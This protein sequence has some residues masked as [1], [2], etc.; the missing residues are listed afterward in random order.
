[1]GFSMTFWEL[2]DLSEEH[3]PYGS[4][5]ASRVVELHAALGEY[6]ARGLPFLAPVNL[7][8]PPLLDSLAGTPDLLAAADLDRARREWASLEPVL[9]SR[10]AFEARFPGVPL[11]AV[12]GDAPS[13]N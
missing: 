1:D 4:V 11:Q 6:P 8:V 5:E 3:V 7:T 2:A 13:Y 10:A 9:G 12:H